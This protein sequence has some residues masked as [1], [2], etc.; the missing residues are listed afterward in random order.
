MKK[1][2]QIFH[3]KDDP[4]HLV[5]IFN[6]DSLE[7]ARQFLE[8]P[9]LQEAMRRSGVV[10]QLK[11]GGLASEKESFVGSFILFATCNESL[12]TKSLY[13][14]PSFIR[15]RYFLGATLHFIFIAFRI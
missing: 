3:V 14:Q 11:N 4:N 6:W 7:H 13:W 1:E 8:S 12:F 10:E 2:F 5:L 9:E 15:G